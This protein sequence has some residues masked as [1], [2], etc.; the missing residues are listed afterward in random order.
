MLEKP[1][2]PDEKLVDCLQA[3]YGVITSELV[4]LPLGADAN[5]AVYRVVTDDGTPLFLKVRRGDFHE[6]VVTVPH[7]LSHQGIPH[8]IPPLVTQLGRLWTR[9]SDFTVT[10]YP[11]VAG[12][13]G[14]ET[15]PLD[16]HWTELGAALHGIH[17]LVLP[18]ALAERIPHETYSPDWRD[19]VRLFQAQAEATMYKEPVAAQCAAFIRA[20]RARI[21][22]LVSRADA[23]A[24]ALQARPLPRV[25]CHADI[26]AG[27]LLISDASNLYIVDWDT[28]SLAPKERD[29][30]YVGAGLSIAD[31]SEQV[32][33][34]YQGYG[35]TEPDAAALAYYRYERIVE[36]IAAFCQQLLLTEEGGVDRAQ[37]LRYLMSSFLPG[38][39]LDRAYALDQSTRHASRFTL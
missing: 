38:H 19:M 37:S 7:W 26:H 12:R 18:P 10:L 11:F 16:R 3:D 24:L 1:D 6:L 25:L 31:T 17:S 13:N 4:F 22:D 29:L 35:P 27:N 21:D 34:F 14:Y 5:T 36:D 20:N 15:T 28:L 8:L 30:M 2:M 9:V 32:A 23:L 39:V 33:L